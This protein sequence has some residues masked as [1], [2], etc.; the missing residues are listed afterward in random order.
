MQT[1]ALTLAAV[2]DELTQMALGAR[3]EDVIQ[4]TP[5]SIA[6]LLY[7]QGA[8]RWLAISAHPQLA[9]MHLAQSRPRKLV[10]E[11]PAFV[12]LLRKHLEGA[13]L[14]TI[15]Q[16]RWERVVELSFARGGPES[17]MAPVWLTAELMGRQSNIIL[18]GDMTS[19]GE[20]LG[21]LHIVPPG[22]NRIRVLMPH[23]VYQPAP[24]QTRTLRGEQVPRLAP[25]RATPA[26]LETAAVDMLATAQDASNTEP[27]TGKRR[28]KAKRDE[29]PTVV[30]LLI[31]H[32]AGCS[33][34][35]AREVAYR[36]LGMADAALAPDLNWNSLSNEMR[37]FAGLAESRAW[38]PTLVYATPD[39]AAPDAFAAFEPQQFPGATLRAMPS[40]NEAL[41][42]YYQDAEWRVTVEGAK[43]DLRRLLQTNRERCIRK[44]KALQGELATLDEARRLREEAD[45]LLA[46]QSELPERA[47][48]VTLENP[49]VESG[50]MESGPAT[51]TLDLDPRY[52][53]IDNANRRYAR[54]HK[55]QRA[56]NQIPVQIAAN[57][58]EL[59]RVEQ[60]Q[61]DLALAETPA[62]IALVREEIV[63]AGYLRAKPDPRAR[64]QPKDGKGKQGKSG[65]QQGKQGSRG[66]TPLRR[67][68]SDGFA[69]L[70][71][72]NSRQ[73]EEVTFHQAAANDLWLHARGV[74][75]AH[76][77]LKSSGRPVP[78][79]TLSEAAALAAYY[80]QARESGAVEVDYTEQRYVRHMKGGGPGMVIY[81]RERT[82]RV[83]PGDLSSD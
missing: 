14:T 82:L 20:V 43:G 41:A 44:A 10:N 55:L 81:E 79:T 8:K 45:L 31:A 36:A 6:L 51:I 67:E 66:G 3:V 47:A 50:L 52:G 58:V 71:G 53:V 74:P 83:A 38:R 27:P 48:S 37:S 76:V 62:E 33:R 60:L 69:L 34:E 40:V 68:S 32:V 5:Q 13:R 26:Q 57:D 2:A 46:F 29:A 54:Y 80:S 22:A 21:A 11:P 24:P 77:I 16:P 64:K 65:T 35:L 30:A 9:N 19:G 42:T 23:V 28:G 4:P 75:G 63:E 78:E 25:E 1:D 15:R 18:R 59:A 39:A 17:G 56:A 73:N 61:A 12:M 7:G 72:K 49:F 70:V